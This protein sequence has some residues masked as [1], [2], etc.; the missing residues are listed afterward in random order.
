[1]INTKKFKL[2]PIKPIQPIQP[3]DSLNDILH[4]YK[5]AL[6]NICQ[7]KNNIL[8]LYLILKLNYELYEKYD[9]FVCTPHCNGGKIIL[10]IIIDVI[11]LSEKFHTNSIPFPEFQKK[12]I[13][14]IKE[15][16]KVKA[17]CI[18]EHL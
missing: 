3:K 2:P 15:S 8:Q 11:T 12:Q 6:I 18:K 13:L 17:P 4:F 16:M 9:N 7:K 1:M 14:L 5:S 10:K